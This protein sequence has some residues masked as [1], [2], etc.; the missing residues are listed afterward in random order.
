MT[1]GADGFTGVLMVQ[2]VPYVMTHS[3]AAASMYPVIVDITVDSILGLITKHG[4]EQYIFGVS[5]TGCRFWC[6]VVL[7]D[8]EQANIVRAGSLYNF[9]GAV[10][11]LNQTNPVRFPLPTPQGA[12]Y[13]VSEE[14]LIVKTETMTVRQPEGVPLQLVG[15]LTLGIFVA[16]YLFF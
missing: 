12:F 15:L 14:G 7:Q 2:S 5:G 9:S 13:N 6:S 4:R 10:E 16:I 11:R 8:M 1:P 3:S